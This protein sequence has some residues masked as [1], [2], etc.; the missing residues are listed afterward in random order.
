MIRNV[1]RRAC[2]L[3]M[4]AG[5]TAGCQS[6]SSGPQAQGHSGGV[7]GLPVAGGGGGPLTIDQAVLTDPSADRLGDIAEA[8]LL[9]FKTNNGM[10]PNLVDLRRVPG[11]ESLI[12]VSP[13]GK[14]YYYVPQGLASPRGNKLLIV[15]DPD[16]SSDGKRWC[17]LASQ[18]HPGAPLTDE[19]FALPEI[20]FRAYLASNP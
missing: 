2:V 16:E 15:Y 10:A 4:A 13:A 1:R 3:L 9:Y 17:I 19:V 6:S 7:Q 12:L 20:E 18:M 8:V 14:E 5:L 11:E